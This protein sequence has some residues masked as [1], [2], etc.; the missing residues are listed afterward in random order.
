MKPP[1]TI[2]TRQG[3]A[4][5][6]ASLLV[7]TFGLPADAPA[8]PLG[9]FTV[10]HFS[11]LEIGAARVRLHYVIDM[12][13]IAALQEL[14]ALD[15]DGDGK[16]SQAE[17]D[18]YAARAAAAH[19]AGLRLSVDGA[20]IPLGLNGQRI[21]LPPGQASLPTLRLECDY[22]GELPTDAAQ[23]NGATRRVSFADTNYE[24]R[25]GWREIVVAPASGVS[26]FDSTAFGSSLSDELRSYPGDMISAPLDERA[27]RLSF[28][29]GTPP[30]A[31]RP[32]VARD[33]ARVEPAARD[34]LAELISV[35]NLTPG[36]VLAG[37]LLA[38]MLG[39]FHAL[40]PGHGKTVVAAYLVGSRGTAKHAAF[41]GLTVTVTHTAGVFA[42][43]IVTLFAAQYVVPETLY[44]ILSFVSGA[45]VV[46]IGLS[47][48]VRRVGAAYGYVEHTHSNEERSHS[49]SEHAHTHDE[50]SHAHGGAAHSH[51]PPGADGE[52]VS[53]RR[54]LALGISGGLLP[55]PSALVVL[56]SAIH[57][58]RIGYGLLL[59]VAFSVGLA[60]VLTCVGLLFVYARRWMERPLASSGLRLQR[61]L[62]A[63]S[64]FVITCAGLFICYQAIGEA[65]YGLSAPG[66]DL[67]AQARAIFSHREPSFARM[68]AFAVLGLGL[69]FGLKHATEVDHV[70][71]VSNIVSEQ[72]KLWRAALVGGLWGV[73]HTASLVIVGVVVLVLRVAISE[74]VASGLEFCVALMIIGLGV[75]TFTRALR[76]RRAP[77]HLHQHRHDGLQHAHIHFHEAG[78]EHAGAI[79][80]HSH[81]VARIGIKPL[82]VGAVHGLA[83]SAAL[84][85]LV[86]AQIP[87]PLV[88]L[89]YLLVFGLGSIAGMLLMSGLVGL[90]FVLSAR[91]L[92]GLHYGLQTV[93]GAL[94]IC[95]GLWYAYETQIA[96]WLFGLLFF[97]A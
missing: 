33:G 89:L 62:P 32:L 84:T 11:R 43:G 53:W 5:V 57:L 16:H 63:L 55:C 73:G 78:T 70:V 35:E 59:V 66:G 87:S 49:Q 6:L 90:P 51:L 10:N 68:S 46:A 52:R 38:F 81:A 85:L 39:G 23:P 12:A 4:F 97:K 91:K 93:A 50:H 83:G 92:S 60:S 48:L 37:L 96:A 14:Q 71:A 76:A 2:R 75:A 45:I 21:T 54:L 86:L 79:A 7:L 44:P 13:E 25:I 15:A 64:A 3:R 95:F 19:I 17:L 82:V 29:T 67:F 42:L 41:L 1:R 74:R 80:P 26:V 47:L 31:A 20:P 27:A 40:S 65:G 34:R 18:A 30:A 88:G 58:R 22:T 72:R 24:E 69:V 28:T 8:H 56:L 9:N 61:V 94:S 36:V 77:V